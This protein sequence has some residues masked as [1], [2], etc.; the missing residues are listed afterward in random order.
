MSNERLNLNSTIGALQIGST[1]TVFLF[2]I[3]TLQV[4]QYY[5]R[6]GE[7]RWY[8]KALVAAVWLLELGHTVCV[9]FEVYRATIVYYGQP[10]KIVS[11][12]A[13]GAVTIIGGIITMLVQN[14]FAIRLY[15][16][17][18]APYR[19][20]GLACLVL[21]SLRCF[22]SLFAG[23]KAIDIESI[24]LYRERWHSLVTTLLAGGAAIDITIATAMLYFLIKKKGHA[25]ERVARL[26]DRLVAYTIRTGL[27]TS[28]AATSVLICFQMMPY[29]LVW[30]ALYTFLA[31]L[32]SNTLLSSLNSR[33]SLR[34]ELLKSSSDPIHLS[35]A[36]LPSRRD[37]L[38]D[39]HLH[40]I[41]IEMK[42]TTEIT[43]DRPRRYYELSV[44]SALP[45]PMEQWD[46]LDSPRSPDRVYIYDS[47]VGKAV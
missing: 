38:N 30:L 15:R 21:S 27:V 20:V 17:L 39:S 14:F 44:D 2:G 42:T 8:V 1:F 19:L 37:A 23:V 40:A 3:V 7:D 16:V 5:R 11:F 35:K 28:V 41:S 45:S 18:P 10:E 25:M 24:A 9:T 31:K 47:G 26:I 36:R 6:F 46:P 34:D 43:V 12:P 32:Y 4:H 33:K 22:T 29:N 13:F